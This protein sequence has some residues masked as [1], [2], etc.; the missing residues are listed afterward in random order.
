MRQGLKNILV[1]T[2]FSEAGN[3][4][5]NTAVRLCKKNNASLHLMHVLETHT[6]Q[7]TGNKH[8]KD[9]ADAMADHEAREHLYAVY[10]S[11]IRDCPI[12]VHIYMPKGIAGEEIVKIATESKIDLLVVGSHGVSGY[13]EFETGSVARFFVK[14]ATKPVLTIPVNFKS[15]QFRNILLP[16]KHPEP[17][18]E[19]CDFTCSL[20]EEDSSV[21]VAACFTEANKK[22][23]VYYGSDFHQ[24]MVSLKHHGLS[25]SRAIYHCR[26]LAHRV[27]D[28]GK[29]IASDLI[30]VSNV[31]DRQ[32][33][34]KA[35][36]TFVQQV[37]NHAGVPVL[38]FRKPGS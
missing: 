38:N 1:A 22:Q 31:S 34:H 16:V 18:G 7:D 25:C 28:I 23:P 15:G 33:I 4:S 14:H 3:N 8:E 37:V 21:H 29:R 24:A 26:N 19:K 30:V 5:V 9:M 11:L 17:L 32:A 27:I 12:Q 36:P 6:L 2:D 35:E 13:R 20:L 10:E